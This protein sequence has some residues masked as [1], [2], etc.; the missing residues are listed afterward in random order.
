VNGQTRTPIWVIAGIALLLVLFAANIA[1]DY[2]QDG[3]ITPFSIFFL[4]ALV[5]G[6][7]LPKIF[8]WPLFTG[9]P[10]RPAIISLGILF[11]V[12]LIS[13]AIRIFVL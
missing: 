9:Q 7:A 8:K 4:I 1:T 10:S 11:V 12:L 5:V 2:F 3:R 13:I 6:F